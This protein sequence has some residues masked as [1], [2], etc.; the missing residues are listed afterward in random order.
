MRI[1]FVLMVILFAIGIACSSS[2]PQTSIETSNSYGGVVTTH[3]TINKKEIVT[4]VIVEVRYIASTSNQKSNVA[5]VFQDG[6]IIILN[7]LGQPLIPTQK[8]VK[9]YICCSWGYIEKIEILE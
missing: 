4:G 6:T 8:L 1:L 5:L 2:I 7:Y 9:L 3:Q